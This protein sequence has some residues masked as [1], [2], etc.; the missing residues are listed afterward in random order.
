MGIRRT[1][2]GGL[3]FQ[4][5]KNIEP[6]LNGECKLRYATVHSLEKDR[7]KRFHLQT[8]S[9]CSQPPGRFTTVL[10]FNWAPSRPIYGPF[11]RIFRSKPIM[12]I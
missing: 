3:G 2:A 5:Q 12:S 9:S 8:E 7:A 6:K 11:I 10:P 4:D 1:G